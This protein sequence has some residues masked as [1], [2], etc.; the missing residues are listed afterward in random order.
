MH[1]LKPLDNI[2]K[3]RNT[4]EQVSWYEERANLLDNMEINAHKLV[5]MMPVFN[6]RQNVT[7]FIETYEYWNLVKDIPGNIIECGVA[8]GNFLMAMAHFSTIFEPHH[9]T[10]KIIGFDTFEGF[11]EPSRQDL[12]STA[13]HMKKGGLAY[14]NYEILQ[15]AI[16]L[17]D[18]NRMI[19]NI[20]KV[21]LFKGDISK[22]FPA[23]LEKHPAATI[24]LLHLDIDLYQPTRD[25]LELAWDR[26]AKGSVLVFDEINHNDYPGE[27]I[28]I[29]EVIGLENIEL[30]RVSC[31]SMAAYCRKGF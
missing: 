31:A 1:K 21:E 7:R 13:A 22:T 27:T 15:S 4:Q 10:R 11:T 12:S 18:K 9:Y 28:A 6:T 8:G 26:M 5:D 20:S 29:R 14:D 30:H 23:Y 25:V 2:E 3:T 24:G 19:G 16:N 17:F